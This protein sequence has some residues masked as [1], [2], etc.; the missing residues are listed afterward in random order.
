MC[1]IHGTH[2]ALVC[3]NALAFVTDVT[4][5]CVCAAVDASQRITTL[6]ARGK[7]KGICPKEHF[8]TLKCFL[9]MRKVTIPREKWAR[10]GGSKNFPLIF[11]DFSA[12]LEFE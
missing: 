10:I 7:S 12:K 6:R 1:S 8:F 5:I 4:A 9:E 3:V 2:C 11:V